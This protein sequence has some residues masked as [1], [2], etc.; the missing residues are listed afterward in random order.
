MAILV[1]TNQ[2]D[3][4]AWHFDNKDTFSIKSAYHVLHD[5]REY[6]ATRQQGSSSSS[7]PGSAKGFKCESP[8]FGVG[9]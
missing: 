7:G 2:D 8:M 1:K 4:V 9:N 3:V 6:E 5:V